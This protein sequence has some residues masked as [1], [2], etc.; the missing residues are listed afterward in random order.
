MNV[1]ENAHTP[2][3]WGIKDIPHLVLID[4]QGTRLADLAGPQSKSKIV[5]I[6]DQNLIL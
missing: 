4:A 1:D 5:E 6:I 2:A 3:E